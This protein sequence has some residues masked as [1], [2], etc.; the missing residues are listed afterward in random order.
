MKNPFPHPA[1]CRH[2][3]GAGIVGLETLRQAYVVARVITGVR[4]FHRAIRRP[5]EGLAAFNPRNHVVAKRRW[6]AF[7]TVRF[8]MAVSAVYELIE[9]VT[10][11]I[12]AEA[13]ES[14]LGTQG[15]NWDTQSDI[16]CALIG[17]TFAIIVLRIPH[18]P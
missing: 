13:A 2:S 18:Y 17:A 5:S 8:C 10:A 15:D 16:F 1:L 6:L 3:H 4:R 11:L 14:F 12:S 7:L 9:W